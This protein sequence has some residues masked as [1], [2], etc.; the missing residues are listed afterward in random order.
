MT[1]RKRGRRG[2]GEGSITRRSDG[3][4]EARISLPGGR[5][6]FYGRTRE[7]VTR[8]LRA[9]QR[10]VDD[11]LPVPSERETV[12][13]FFGAW[14]TGAKS[15]LRLST[16]TTYEQYVRLHLLPTLGRVRVAHLRPQQLQLLYQ[17]RLA[18]GLSAMTVRHLH[19][20]IH[21]GLAQAV[22][23]GVAGRNVADLVDPPR[24][25]RQSLDVL[26]AAE[27]ANLLAAA[28]GD[29]LEALYVLAVTTGMRRGE[30]LA[31]RWREVDLDRGVLAVTGSLQRVGGQLSIGEPK[32]TSSRRQVVLSQAAVRALR[33]HR[34]LQAEHQLG[35][36]HWEDLDLVFTN[37]IGRPIEP[38]NLLRRSYWPLLERAGLRRVRFH[39]LRHTAAT[40]L[41][42]R[43]VHAKVASEM[44]G[45]S[46]IGITLD[47]YSHV[48]EA[49][50]RDAASAM[51]AILGGGDV[52]G[53]KGP[54]G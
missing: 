40:L 23:W 30:L 16:W 36:L 52:D 35:A 39:D 44:L 9:A 13:S 19:A 34:V 45:H 32:T 46:T 53:R 11:G 38:G 47:L 4:W 7:E 31:L 1:D 6:C 18:L 8:K 3:R 54:T 42:S 10:A 51:D 17:E 24:Q 25:G 26:T 29:R 49:M 50:Q 48:S 28:R 27:V 43:G 22:R 37:E 15:T 33:A 21:R 20:I 14:L 5:R 2:R 41:L 12:A